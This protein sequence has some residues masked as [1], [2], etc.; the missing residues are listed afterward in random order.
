MSMSAKKPVKYEAGEIDRVRVVEDFLPPPKA[1]VPRQSGLMLRSA[2]KER[3]SK[4]G[5]PHRPIKS[6]ASSSRR[7]APRGSSG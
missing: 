4:H 2:P 3:V 5:P 6:G 7:R 1:L